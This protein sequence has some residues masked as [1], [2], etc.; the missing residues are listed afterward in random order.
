MLAPEKCIGCGVC[1]AACPSDAMKMERRAEIHVPPETKK[2]Q[3]ARIAKE[4]GRV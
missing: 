3:F 1:A 2:E 4:K